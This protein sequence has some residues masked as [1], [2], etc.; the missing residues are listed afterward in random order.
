MLQR[1]DGA[2]AGVGTES[3][4]R[5]VLGMW[6]VSPFGPIVDAMVERADGARVLIAPTSDVADF[7]AA[8]Y[9]FDEIRIESTTLRIADQRWTVTAATMRV[10]ITTGRRTA[11]GQLLSLIPRAVVSTRPWCRLVDPVARRVRRGVRTFGTA[12][13]G[14]CE[15][16]CALDEHLVTEVSAELDGIDLGALRPVIPPV[17]FGFGSTPSMPSLVRVTTLIEQP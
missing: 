15:Y 16:Y 3:G 17:R 9:N 4:V 11:V 2:I 14:R 5:L 8:T 1:F 7:I 10:T 13:N 12:G 6:P